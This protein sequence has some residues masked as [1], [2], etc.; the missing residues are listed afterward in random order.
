MA[1]TVGWWQCWPIRRIRGAAG[2]VHRSCSVGVAAAD[3][4]DLRRTMKCGW[5]KRTDACGRPVAVGD[6]LPV[7]AAVGMIPGGG[8]AVAAGHT[9][10]CSGDCSGPRSKGRRHRSPLPG[11]GCE[12]STP[13][14]SGSPLGSEEEWANE[15]PVAGIRSRQQCR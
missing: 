12:Q 3:V 2:R 13:K 4:L 14:L 8:S 1:S 5:R 10:H 9:L 7:A 11:V 15:H 6:V